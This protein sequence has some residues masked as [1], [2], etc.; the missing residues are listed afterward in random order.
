MII[1]LKKSKL[2]TVEP[3][4]RFA[5]EYKVPKGIWYEIYKRHALLE[6]DSIALRGFFLL[7][8]NKKLSDDALQRW[9]IRTEIYV[10]AQHVIRLGVEVADSSYF[11]QFEAPLLQELTRGM[12]F[13]VTR[14]SRTIV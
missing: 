4:Q 11:G 14:E 5:K 3:A 8:T 2:F 1:H 7:K 10:R 12:Q 6:H 9:I 13:G